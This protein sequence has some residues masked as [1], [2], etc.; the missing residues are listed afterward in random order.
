MTFRYV[1]YLFLYNSVI[2]F[3]YLKN[4]NFAGDRVRNSGATSADNHFKKNLYA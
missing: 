1:T 4:F 3:S 2:C